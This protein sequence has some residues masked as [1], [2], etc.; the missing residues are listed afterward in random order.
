MY[1]V[2]VEI[3][4]KLTVSEQ[5]AELGTTSAVVSLLETA[6]FL[7]RKIQNAHRQ[8]KELQKT[9][10]DSS[11]QLQ[12][13]VQSLN[14]VKSEPALRTA[15]V[16]VQVDAIIDVAEELRVLLERLRKRQ[17]KSP[18]RQ[19]M[20]TITSGDEDEK[21]ITSI[22][23][24]VDSARA[25]LTLRIVVAQVGLIGTLNDGFRVAS[26]TLAEVNEKANSCLGTNLVLA[27]MTRGRT[28][29]AG[30]SHVIM[31]SHQLQLTRRR[32]GTVALL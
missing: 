10:S 25:E 13:L 5:A 17:G 9:L 8:V 16:M 32:D 21:H 29:D 20:H 7:V 28:P 19:M 26:V 27:D 11:T 22:V 4:S 30:E 24:R 1:H 23:S 2:L 18:G 31:I 12:G 6:I 14:L 15:S 3:G